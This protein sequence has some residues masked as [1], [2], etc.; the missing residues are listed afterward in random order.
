E[1]AAGD[2]IDGRPEGA[3]IGAR[4]GGLAHLERAEEVGGERIE[5][6][7]AG[8][9]GRGATV[10]RSRGRQSLETIQAHDGEVGAETAHGDAAAFA[11][12]AVDGDAG[13]ALQRFREIRV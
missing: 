11:V 9:I 10:A 2:E 6:E 8:A 13:Q 3:L 1:R 5:V 4:G 7:L 12:L